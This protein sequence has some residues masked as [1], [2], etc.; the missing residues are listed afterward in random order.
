[1]NSGKKNNKLLYLGLHILLMFYAVGGI[2]SK[3]AAQAEFLSVNYLVSYGAVLVILMIYAVFWQIILKKIPLTVA[4]ANKSVTVIW[5]II[6]GVLFFRETITVT[7]LIGAV[8]IIVGILIVVDADK[9][10]GQCIS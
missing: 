9:E 10:D 6:Y 5:G 7:N 3:S 2:F 1:M 4:M 8:V